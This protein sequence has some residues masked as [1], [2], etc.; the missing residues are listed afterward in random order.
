ID[1]TIAGSVDG[2]MFRR[3]YDDVFTGDERWSALETPSGEL[4]AWDPDSTYVRQPP[5]FE[6][7]EREAGG[8]ADVEGARV[9]VRLG[10]SVT[11]DHISPAGATC[12]FPAAR[13]RG[14]CTSPTRRRGRSTTS[15]TATA[16]RECRRSCSPA[17]S[18]APGRR[19]TGPQRGRT[20]SESAP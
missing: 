1:E 6:G 8:F 20:C 18:T 16:T 3:V 2:E 12:S 7:M 11:T 4:F 5:Y 17:R 19:A 10:D 13:A 14:P 15:R 9:L